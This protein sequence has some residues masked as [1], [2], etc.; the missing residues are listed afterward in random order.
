MTEL[1]V[2][3]RPSE[4]HDPPCIASHNSFPRLLNLTTNGLILLHARSFFRPLLK[5]LHLKAFTGS[6]SIWRDLLEALAQLAC[7]ESLMI[8]SKFQDI[9]NGVRHCTDAVLDHPVGLPKLRFLRTDCG[10]VGWKTALLLNNLDFPTHTRLHISYNQVAAAESMVRGHSASEERSALS[11]TLSSKLSRR[12]QSRT[13]ALS[14]QTLHILADDH[15]DGICNVEG[16]EA[17]CPPDILCR[18]GPFA[19]ADW[20]SLPSSSPPPAITLQ[21]C[22]DS[23]FAHFDELDAFRHVEAL[24]LTSGPMQRVRAGIANLPVHSVFGL[25][26]NVRTLSVKGWLARNVLDAMNPANTGELM[27]P[28]V[29][30]LHIQTFKF[31]LAESGLPLSRV[32]QRRAEIGHRLEKLVLSDCMGVKGSELEALRQDV[33]VVWDGRWLQG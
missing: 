6:A 4:A 18:S 30:T 7:L 11:R 17:L 15:I 19:F 2:H 13:D 20:K 14:I 32:L 10:E 29:K 1:T 27:L 5:T 3:S 9:P 8:E 31:G 26:S 25:L 28:S 22:V 12:S 23:I 21:S 16:W 24:K 33:E